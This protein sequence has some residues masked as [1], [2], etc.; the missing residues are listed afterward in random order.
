MHNCSNVANARTPPYAHRDLAAS[1]CTATRPACLHQYVHVHPRRLTWMVGP[2]RPS[3]ICLV[4]LRLA[5]LLNSQ[6]SPCRSESLRASSCC[7]G[8]T[9][10][11][12]VALP[13]ATS[14]KQN[15]LEEG[16]GKAGS[17]LSKLQFPS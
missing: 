14:A 12:S 5:K 4:Y 6:I 9:P 17:V 11:A 13:G 8:R 3:I 1:S 15:G 2:A 7:P 16:A 10:A